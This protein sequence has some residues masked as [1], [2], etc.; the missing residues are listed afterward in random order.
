MGN[1]YPATVKK[2]SQTFNLNTVESDYIY[3]QSINGFYAFLADYNGLYRASNRDFKKRLD[4]VKLLNNKGLQALVNS[5]RPIIFIS[6]HM[7]FFHLGFLKLAMSLEQESSRE[8]HIFRMPLQ[9]QNNKS[10]LASLYERKSHRIK[11]L[12]A[13]RDGGRKAFVEL[14][15]N[16]A[17]AMMVDLEVYV[18]TRECVTFFGEQC[19][20]QSGAATLAV[21]TR[22]VIVPIINYVDES[23][24]NIIRI[25]KQLCS[26]PVNTSET[27]QDAVKRLTQEISTQMESWL[28]IDPTQVHALASIMSLVSQENTCQ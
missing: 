27:N 20:M 22:A 4:E 7:G 14:R 21:T 23:G 5:D 8:L 24:V 3:R 2:L 26:D 10:D 18:K 17:V 15:K 19:Y 28:R 16:N 11:A 13:D 1:Y 9:E 6:I 25:E 12:R